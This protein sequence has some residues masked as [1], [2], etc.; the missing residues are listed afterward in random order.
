MHIVCISH[1]HL[2]PL[3]RN[4]LRKISA[5]ATNITCSQES[6]AIVAHPPVPEA[7][8]VLYQNLL[9]H[10]SVIHPHNWHPSSKGS[11]NIGREKNRIKHQIIPIT[12]ILQ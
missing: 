11:G 7:A 2:L 1:N 3:C 10:V 5:E 8:E 6:H 12:V 9:D 4:I